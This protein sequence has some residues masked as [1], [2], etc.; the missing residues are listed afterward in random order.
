MPV[1]KKKLIAK[2]FLTRTKSAIFVGSFYLL[3]TLL[4]VFFNP[5][6]FGPVASLD[7]DTLSKIQIIL[8]FLNVLMLVPII[9]F[10]AKEITNLCFAR[11]K[12]IFIFTAIALFTMTIAASVFLIGTRYKLF[13]A[14]RKI[15]NVEPFRYFLLAMLV[16]VLF[17][18]I[19]STLI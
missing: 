6:W 14:D 16:G 5:N 8:N 15:D 17:F 9:Y 12:G 10:V 1:E 4:L 11:Y 7:Q 3:Y 18:T 13:F 2:T 19:L